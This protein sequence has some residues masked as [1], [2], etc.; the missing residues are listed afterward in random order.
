MTD[1][2]VMLPDTYLVG[3]DGGCDVRFFS[4]S[5]PVAEKAGYYFPL[6]SNAHSHAPMYVREEIL[7]Y[8]Y[9]GR[10]ILAEYSQP[11][12]AFE[13]ALAV[14]VGMEFLGNL[15]ITWEILASSWNFNWLPVPNN[16]DI[17]LA[18]MAKRES[19][20]L[21]KELGSIGLTLAQASL[22]KK[23]HE[24]ASR[25]SMSCMNLGGNT[26]TGQQYD[27]RLVLAA[28]IWFNPLDLEREERVKKLFRLY[29]RRY[30]PNISWE[31]FQ[32]DFYKLR[33]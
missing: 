13:G 16:P 4:R 1:E 32:N 7:E 30:F 20:A 24:K 6:E 10:L 22:G 18:Y 28:S 2:R 19:E 23:D 3:F 15:Q 29:T 12:P 21:G 33:P 8:Q 9:I 11:I 26:A 25:I 5:L 31:H 14:P 27:L 17:L